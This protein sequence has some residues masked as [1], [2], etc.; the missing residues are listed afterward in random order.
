MRMIRHFR[1]M[2]A[3]I[4]LL[5]A[6]TGI[7]AAQGCEETTFRSKQGQLYLEAE[8]LL[9]QE[10]K[11]TAGALRKLNELRQQELN[12][13]E[14][15]AA[16][17]LSAQIKV[18]SG[19]NMGAARE[20]EA[21]VARG[22][23]PAEQRLS[24]LKNIAYLYLQADDRNTALR[25]FEDWTRAGGKPNRD[26]MFLLGQLYYQAGNKQQSL[27]YMEQVF[28][29][30][31][32]GAERT[33]Y[34]FLILLYD[35][36]GQRAKR[37]RLL[38]SLLQRDPSDKQLWQIIASDYYEGGDERKAF[39]MQKAMYFAGLLKESG[40]I[41]QIVNFYNQFDVPF[42]AAKVLEKEMNAGRIEK[43]FKNLDQLANLYQV[44]RE[45]E[46]AIPVI[47]EMA[48][49]QDTGR[50]YERLGRSYFEMGRWQ[51][52]EEAL[53]QAE[54]KGNMKE[55]GYGW[56]LIGQ[57]LY[58]RD[59]RGPA[60]EAF[61]EAMKFRDGRAGGQGWLDFMQNEDDTQRALVVFEAEQDVITLKAEQERCKQ[62]I[63]VVGEDAAGEE[64]KTVA[65]RLE[66]ATATLAEIKG[67]S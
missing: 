41:M 32:P 12:C 63:T 47:K 33:V 27:N 23:V 17:G 35:E 40:E 44:A 57:S 46:R 9:L 2:T 36:T 22:Y 30:D 15:A 4:A 39:E 61:R 24:T 26:E 62:V 54:A 38:E 52:A 34:D 29:I 50:V 67:Q 11:D 5:A 66:E 45:Y 19:D 60:R 21:L 58:N 48:R 25:K 56:V 51:D 1:S 16:I 8:N 42:E 49:I 28:Q 10:P 37:A 65:E 6:G 53:R 18:E 13:Y 43:N 14:E 20:L 7:A 3:A 59:Q 55:P 64:C 31:G